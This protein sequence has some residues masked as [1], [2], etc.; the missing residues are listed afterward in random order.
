MCSRTENLKTQKSPVKP[1]KIQKTPIKPGGLGFLKKRVFLNPANDNDNS[2]VIA[3]YYSFI[4]PERM[5]GWVGLVGWHIYAPLIEC[6]FPPFLFI[7]C[8]PFWDTLKR[9]CGVKENVLRGRESWGNCLIQVHSCYQPI[10]CVSHWWCQERYPAKMAPVLW[11][12]SCLA[13]P[14][15][16]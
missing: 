3:A 4:D 7:H 10:I 15:T 2:R 14:N 1:N 16:Q 13:H 6:T 12:M 11:K 8:Y 9:W 5:K